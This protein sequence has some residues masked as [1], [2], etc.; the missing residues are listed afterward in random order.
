MKQEQLDISRMFLNHL[1]PKKETSCFIGRL[2]KKDN[3]DVSVIIP[4]YNVEKYARTAIESVLGQATE[5]KVQLICVD[6]GST[7]ATGQILDEYGNQEDLVVVHQ[8]NK[9]SSSA[10]NTGLLYADAKYLFFLDSDDY[11]I[12]KCLDMMLQAAYTTGADIVEGSLQSFTDEETEVVLEG[13][14]GKGEN[15]DPFDDNGYMCAK[16]YKAEVF[17]NIAFPEGYW[18]EDG[19]YGYLIASR[20]TS[21]Y[22]IDYPVYMYRMNIGGMSAGF[23]GN[24]KSIDAYWLREIIFDDMDRFGIQCD[25]RIYEKLLDE[26]VM[27]FV[28]T[29]ELDMNVKTAIFFLTLAWIKPLHDI[30]TSRNKFH[31]VLEKG[32]ELENYQTYSDGCAIFWNNKIAGGK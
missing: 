6:D 11:I 4:C 29:N 30:Y 22:S 1:N 13:Y 23:K 27:T 16:L 14:S 10:R 32:I 20:I 24:P 18:Y 12:D 26:I 3:Y 7:D 8:E 17:D 21:L 9:G 25:Q 2:I 31:S 15:K 5:Y 28:R 19:I